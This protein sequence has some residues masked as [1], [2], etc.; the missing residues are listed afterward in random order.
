LKRVLIVGSFF[1]LLAVACSRINLFEQTKT[2]PAH[3]WDSGNKP[4]FTFHISDTA[5]AYNIYVVVR[6]N[7]AYHYNNL[8]LNVYVQGPA[9]SAKRYQ[10]DLTLASNE[11]GWLGSGMDDIYEHRIPITKEA[12]PFFRKPGDYQF[13]LEHIM[14]ENPLQNVMN[15]GLRVEKAK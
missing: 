10:L 2:I 7:D 5:S 11:K 14:R 15:V 6:H 9:D 8:W 13:T 12:Y 1:L 4:R 3:A